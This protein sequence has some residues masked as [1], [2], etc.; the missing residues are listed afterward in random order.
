[1]KTLHETLYC[2]CA[3]ESRVNSPEEKNTARR[4][5]LFRRDDGNRISSPYMMFCL[6]ESTKGFKEITKAEYLR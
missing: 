6:S 1:M 5:E 2:T 4:K 3:D